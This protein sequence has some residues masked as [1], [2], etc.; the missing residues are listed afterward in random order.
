MRCPPICPREASPRDPDSRGV[1]ETAENIYRG[2]FPSDRGVSGI[3]VSAITAAHLWA[4][5]LS[6]WRVCVLVN[7]TLDQLL[8]VLEPLM[9]RRSGEKFDQLKTTPAALIRSHEVDGSDER[10]FSIL[11]ECVYDDQG[12]K[13]PAHAHIAICDRLKAKIEFK[14][15]TFLALQ[16]GLKLLFEQGQQAW[17]RT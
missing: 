13:H 15:E 10:S 12:N 16:E 5:E 1:V 17:Q 11:D 8:A 14:D 7:T 3:R 9:I 6:V 2:F 4:G